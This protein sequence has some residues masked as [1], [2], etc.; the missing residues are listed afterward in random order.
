MAWINAQRPTSNSWGRNR[1]NAQHS[2]RVPIYWSLKFPTWMLDVG[3]WMLGVETYPTIPYA[4]GT[5]VLGGALDARV[6]R[7]Y[8][9]LRIAFICSSIVVDRGTILAV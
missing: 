2:R 6:A 7:L 5:M 3:R 4:S 9:Q 8:D 1:I